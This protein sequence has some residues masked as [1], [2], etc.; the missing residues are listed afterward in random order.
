MFTQEDITKLTQKNVASG[1]K[2][3]QALLKGA[4]QLF[5][6][7]LNYIRANVEEQ[8]KFAQQ[9]NATT[10]AQD[11]SALQQ[12]RLQRIAETGKEVLALSTNVQTD[13]REIVDERQEEMQQDAKKASDAFSSSAFYDPANVQKTFEQFWKNAAT[14]F[15]TLSHLMQNTTQASQKPAASTKAKA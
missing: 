12:S 7:Q 8:A 4:E 14:A 9:F 15:D 13:L 6:L 2:A 3:S 11:L 1:V 10:L 5:Q